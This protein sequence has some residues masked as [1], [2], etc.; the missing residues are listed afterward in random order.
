MSTILVHVGQAGNQ[1]G[2]SLWDKILSTPLGPIPFLDD[3]GKARALLIDAEP[4]VLASS[5]VAAAEHQPA[6]A[7][8]PERQ[9]GIFRK[10]NVVFDQSGRGNNWAL[11][12]FGRHRN[13]GSEGSLTDVALAALEKEVERCD[14]FTGLVLTHS[15]TGG[16]GS[17]IGSR[18]LEAVYD[19]YPASFRLTGSLLPSLCA[20]DSSLQVGPALY[21][22]PPPLPRFFLCVFHF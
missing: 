10:A 2:Q 19:R 8:D 5:I 4:K 16:T 14:V 22:V 9:F 15:T 11:G 3:H 7:A 1:L 6:A 13:E 12:Y 21:F 18:M 17:G 20:G